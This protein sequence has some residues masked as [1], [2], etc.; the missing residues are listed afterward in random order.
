ML[1][2]GGVGTYII[3]AVFGT[4]LVYIY[5][6]F[7]FFFSPV[8][9]SRL[10]FGRM[11]G[12]ALFT[13]VFSGF[14]SLVVFSVEGVLTLF[15]GEETCWFIVRTMDRRIDT[16]TYTLTARTGTSSG[17]TLLYIICEYFHLFFLFVFLS[18]LFS[19]DVHQFFGVEDCISA[20]MSVVSSV[21][22]T[23]SLSVVTQWFL[24]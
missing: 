14:F 8:F 18:F 19:L 15:D 7:L 21:L 10:G 5:T 2:L 6:L 20:V 16:V 17:N 4:L 9:P 13:P 22:I 23:Y 3:S 11:L 1:T 12:R 24:F